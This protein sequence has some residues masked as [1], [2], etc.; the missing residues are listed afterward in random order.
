MIQLTKLNAHHAISE[1]YHHLADT[2]LHGSLSTYIYEFPPI[3]LHNTERIGS[4]TTIAR[5]AELVGAAKQHY[6][7][8]TRKPFMLPGQMTAIKSSSRVTPS[9]LTRYQPFDRGRFS[10]TDTQK[11]CC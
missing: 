3:G 7:K 9:L 1:S 4:A 10:L 8:L 2:R 11:L 5:D 6:Q